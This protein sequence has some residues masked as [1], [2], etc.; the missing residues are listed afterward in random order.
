MA[1]TIMKMPTAE[2]TMTGIFGLTSAENALRRQGER[3]EEA[4]RGRRVGEQ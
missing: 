1:S 4:N 2:P 3:E